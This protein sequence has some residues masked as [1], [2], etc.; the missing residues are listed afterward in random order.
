VIQTAVADVVRTDRRR[1]RP[2]ERDSAATTALRRS[3]RARKD[4]VSHRVAVANQLRAHL[5]I[6]FPAAAGLFADID[7]D[8]S[9][10]FL[11][12]FTTGGQASGLSVRRLA[13]WPRLARCARLRDA[14]DGDTGD[15]PDGAA[16]LRAEIG[17]ARA[18]AVE[19]GSARGGILILLDGRQQRRKIRHCY[20]TYPSRIDSSL[21]ILGWVAR[22][23]PP[24]RRSPE[25]GGGR[26]WHP[27]AG[28]RHHPPFAG[29]TFSVRGREFGRA[30][31]GPEA[32]PRPG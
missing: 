11:E 24:H 18:S 8:I 15:H 19:D 7:S 9:L 30:R 13:A 29:S 10:R 3:V 23:S 27:V 2:L 31:G 22:P 17:D 32:G 6:V 12:R 21:P 5:Q 26:A 25:P 4:L 1:L 28:G 20:R 14:P 16:R